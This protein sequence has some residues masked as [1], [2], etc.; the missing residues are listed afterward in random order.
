MN[1]FFW[2]K[3]PKWKTT[4]YITSLV[5]FIVLM[6]FLNLHSPIT[7][8]A[9]KE[10]YA[11]LILLEEKHPIYFSLALFAFYV[12]SVSLVIPDSILLSLLAGALYPLPLAIL[13][14]SLCEMLGAL[15]FFMMFKEGFYTYVKKRELSLL[16]KFSKDDFLHHEIWYL[17]F[18]RVSHIIPFW[19]TN[20][21]AILF[22][23]NPY[24]FMWTTFV[25]TIP[26][27]AVIA[28]AGEKLK[29][30]LMQNTTFSLKDVFNTTTDT[31][32]LALGALMLL[33]IVAKKFFLRR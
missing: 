30:A 24:R 27:S 33:P 29:T 12:F 32:L 6:I 22:K 28:I 2:Q 7:F 20:V 23:T 10:K 25:G 11:E 13:F 3:R 4:L 14:I 21:V 16:S 1:I 15:I 26:L 8:S 18:L 19:F 17:L 31:T 9:L 5:L